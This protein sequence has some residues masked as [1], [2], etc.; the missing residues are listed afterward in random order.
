MSETRRHGF[1][2]E[3]RESCVIKLTELYEQLLKIAVD[4]QKA[5]GK[6]SRVGHEADLATKVL[7]NFKNE[8]ANL[9]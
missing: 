4:V 3:E 6:T 7:F 5:Y 1:S 9:D 2:P 8:V